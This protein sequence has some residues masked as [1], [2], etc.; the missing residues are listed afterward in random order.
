MRYES[1]LA[2]QNFLTEFDRKNASVN[3]RQFLMD[4]QCF[5][6]NYQN[7][8]VVD[9]PSKDISKR[10]K[11]KFLPLIFIEFRD[12]N[13]SIT[14]ISLIGVKQ[15]AKERNHLDNLLF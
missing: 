1:E 12:K 8:S 15:P 7:F 6:D 11:F 14:P 3:I 9:G 4:C 2:M 5:V 10:T 13:Y